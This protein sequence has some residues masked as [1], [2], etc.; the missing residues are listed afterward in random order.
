MQA[1][2]LARR[3]ATIT[4]FGKLS[5][6]PD[7]NIGIPNRGHSKLRVRAHLHPGVSDSVF[8][9]LEAWRLGEA[10]NGRSI[11]SR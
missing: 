6:R 10:K 1:D 3:R 8:D 4:R 7:Q 5:G 11:I 9:R 2:Q